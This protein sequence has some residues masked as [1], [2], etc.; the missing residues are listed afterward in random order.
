MYSLSRPW[1]SR[2]AASDDLSRVVEQL[3]RCGFQEST[4]LVATFG[5]PQLEPT[6]GGCMATL[7]PS[8]Q[9]LGWTAADE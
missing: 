1:C 5:N 3:M 6:Q 8:P 2:A 9:R 4:Y 7:K